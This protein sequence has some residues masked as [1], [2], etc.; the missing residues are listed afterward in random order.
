MS[1]LGSSISRTSS[2]AAT[3]LV[4]FPTCRLT[5][6]GYMAAADVQFALLK[7]MH[8]FVFFVIMLFGS[9][10]AFMC[11]AALFFYLWLTQ[12]SVFQ[13][14]EGFLSFSGSS[15][16]VSC[17]SQRLMLSVFTFFTVGRPVISPLNGTLQN[18]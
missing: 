13:P 18:V 11:P 6:T 16:Y 3:E 2:A 1:P 17:R 12:T 10:G 4:F 7:E 5:D 15:A 9:T 8:C 14:V